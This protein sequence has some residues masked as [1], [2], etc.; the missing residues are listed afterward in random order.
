MIE[1]TGKNGTAK[2]FTEMVEATALDQVKTMMDHVITLNTE[3]RLMPDIHFGKGATV[4]TSIQL[5]EN[6]DEWKVSPNVVGVDIGCGMLSYKLSLKK[7]NR[8]D[9]KMLRQLDEAIKKYVPSGFK[10]HTRIDKAL[11]QSLNTFLKELNLPLTGKQHQHITHSVGTL[12][13]GNHFI[14]LAQDENKDY[15]LTVHSGS[16]NLGVQVVNYHQGIAND[17]STEEDKKMGLAYLEGENLN[18]YLNDMK[19]AQKFAAMNR[20]AMLDNIVE[21]LPYQI[22]VK[23]EFDSIHNFISIEEGVIRKGATSAR[24]GE[25]LII[26]LNMKDGSIIA[27]GRGN[28][29]WNNSAPH[30]AGRTMSRTAAKKNLSLNEFKEQM[31]EVYST[32]VLKSTIDEAPNAYKPSTNI[33]E[34]AKDTMKVIHQLKPVYNFKAH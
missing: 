30:G 31:A 28:A 24:E 20:R 1:V 19:I 11:N 26:P 23:D 21:N 17:K 7:Q 34:N 18:T 29:D 13:G 3:V 14:E 2:V 12:G 9:E 32:S 25:R 4:G 5:P 15:W 6:R 16:R 8:F 10:V 22:E 27:E 33:L